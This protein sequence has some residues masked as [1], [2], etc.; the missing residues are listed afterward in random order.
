MGRSPRALPD[1]AAI[2]KLSLAVDK[3]LG[4]PHMISVSG[5]KLTGK[6]NWEFWRIWDTYLWNISKISRG[7]PRLFHQSK[8]HNIK[9]CHNTGRCHDGG[10]GFSGWLAETGDQLTNQS[11]LCTVIPVVF[12][13][14]ARCVTLILASIFHLELWDVQKDR[15]ALDPLHVDFSALHP[16]RIHHVREA[17]ILSAD[18]VDFS[19][20]SCRQENR[21]L[22]MLLGRSLVVMFALTR[23]TAIFLN[24]IIFLSLKN[25]HKMDK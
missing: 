18:D 21:P 13:I 22:E 8:Q 23:C 5:A 1:A 3:A 9:P 25:L 19:G 15:A 24:Y 6:M 14:S 10:S 20:W 2:T 17:G 11:S 16:R 7:V 12:F 4:R